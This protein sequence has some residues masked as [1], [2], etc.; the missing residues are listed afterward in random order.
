[1]G[2]RYLAAGQRVKF[3]LRKLAGKSRRAEAEIRSDRTAHWGKKEARL[4]K[5][6]LLMGDSATSRYS[7]VLK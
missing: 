7:S 5:P 3:E 2:V 6:L 4:E 1:M